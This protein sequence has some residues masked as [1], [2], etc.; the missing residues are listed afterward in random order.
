MNRSV[1]WY[2]CLAGHWALVRTAELECGKEVEALY[3]TVDEMLGHDGYF[4]WRAVN[5]N[6]RVNGGV[7]T[8]L[9]EAKAKA[10]KWARNDWV[11]WPVIRDEPTVKS[12]VTE[13]LVDRGYDGLYNEC[14][15]GCGIDDLMPCSD[16]QNDC[17]AAHAYRCGRCSKSG[18]CETCRDLDIMEVVE[19]TTTYGPEGLC[20]PSYR[21][22]PH[23]EEI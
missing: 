20:E 4:S 18:T 9:K 11:A 10:A 13:Y 3:A 6:D 17:V 21:E 23:E 8:S 22:S 19:G 16:C 15:C 5:R 1:E 2:Y 14:G 12:I 7:C